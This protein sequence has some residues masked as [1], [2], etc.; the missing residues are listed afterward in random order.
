M[1]GTTFTDSSPHEEVIA[2]GLPAGRLA[3]VAGATLLAAACLHLP[4]PNLERLAA[5]TV[6]LLC[7]CG[8]GWIRVQG[9][10]LATWALRA[11][12]AVWRTRLEARF[13]PTRWRCVDETTSCPSGT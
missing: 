5:G 11:T 4:G 2:W 12:R 6:T 3:L 9:V 7:G 1:S 13:S 8:L 10:P